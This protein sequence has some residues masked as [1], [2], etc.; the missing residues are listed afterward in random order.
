MRL[1]TMSN[2]HKVKAR[3]FHLDHTEVKIYRN[4]KTSPTKHKGELGASR[5]WKERTF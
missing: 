5:N 1:F 2:N 4:T 3:Y